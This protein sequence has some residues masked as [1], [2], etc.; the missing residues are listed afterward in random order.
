MDGTTLETTGSSDFNK[1]SAK[2]F[3]FISH[4]PEQTRQIGSDLGELTQGGNLILLVGDLGAGKTCFAQGVAR[5]LGFSGYAS[6]PSF[7]LVREYPGRLKVYHIDFYRLDTIEE[8]ADLGIDDY[9]VGDGVCVIEWADKVLNW[10]PRDHL[11]IKF[12]HLAEDE[13]RLRFEPRGKRYTDLVRQLKEK[14][15]LR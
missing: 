11:V 5:G 13:R 14:W 7:V 6:S 8:I 15:N 2:A 10:L 9:L 12:A 3:E 4:S 1:M